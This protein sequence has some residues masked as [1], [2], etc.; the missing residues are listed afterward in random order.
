M[1]KKFFNYNFIYTK[2][3]KL[4]NIVDII[5]ILGLMMTKQIEEKYY[6]KILNQRNFIVYIYIYIQIRACKNGGQDI[7]SKISACRSSTLQKYGAIQA[8]A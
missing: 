1:K 7:L 3:V 2:Y 5:L 8:N 6:R 4:I